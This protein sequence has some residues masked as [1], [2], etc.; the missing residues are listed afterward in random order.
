MVISFHWSLLN[1]QDYV[2]KLI[3][4]SLKTINENAENLFKCFIE[5]KLTYHIIHPFIVNNSVVF[6]TFRVFNHVHN[7][8]EN[9]FVTSERSPLPPNHNSPFSLPTTL[10]SPWLP[11][12]TSCFYGFAYSGDFIYM[13]SQNL[14][15]FVIGSFT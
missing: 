12:F 9:I 8:F 5:I 2:E 10:P 3:A 6:L 13:E 14:W 1:I 11:L 7:Q 4:S 15:S